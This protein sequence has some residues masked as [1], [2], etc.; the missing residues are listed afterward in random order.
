MSTV[1]DE[2]E[3]ST[4][5]DGTGFWSA[6][7]LVAEREINSQVRTK[8]FWLTFGLFVVGIFAASILPGFFS[9][10]STTVAVVGSDVEQVITSTEAE[11]EVEQ[12]ADPAAAEELVR[13]GDVDA[14]IVPD[15]SGES[16]LGLRIL[17]LDSAPDELVTALS[18]APPVDLLDDSDVPEGLR[19]AVSFLFAMVFFIFSIGFGMAI[20]QS[21]VTEKQTRIVE[22][23]VATISVRALLAGKIAGYSLLVFAQVAVL[24]ILTPVALRI[25]EQ[26]DLLSSLSGVLGWF[27]PFFI[28]GFILLAA[29][30]AV[31]GSLVSRQEDLGSSSSVVMTLVMLPYFGVIFFNDNSLVMT[32][33]SYV[34]FSSPVAMPVRMFTE[35][36]QAWEPIASLL[37]LIV[38][39]IITVLA[40]SRLYTGSLMQTGSKVKLSRAWGGAK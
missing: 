40:A 15:T 27:V 38:T 35:D 22:I 39:L 19:Y 10:G 9:G 6:T 36:A 18:V 20:A 30:W 21:V 16:P 34:P 8:S 5:T 37:V 11:L 23:L 2:R 1:T 3:T 25:G 14:A 24:A 7:R 32:V 17:A 29:L 33:L 13:S 26:G 12:V 31:A 4:R 28:L